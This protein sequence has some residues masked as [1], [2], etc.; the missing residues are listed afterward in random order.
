GHQD[1]Q[2][3]QGDH[4]DGQ[5]RRH[6]PAGGP[7]PRPVQLDGPPATSHAPALLPMRFE[8]VEPRWHP[9]RGAPAAGFTSRADQKSKS[10]SPESS[11][12]SAFA[13]TAVLVLPLDLLPLPL[14][15][16]TSAVAKR[17]AGPASSTF[18]SRVMRSLPSLSVSSFCWS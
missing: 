17:S 11:P 2:H 8:S 10:S 4:R 3:R 12:E 5:P 7:P 6:K 14:R 9:S 16:V 13:D 15:R 18:S 1:H